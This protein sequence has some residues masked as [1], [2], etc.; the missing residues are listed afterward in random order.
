LLLLKNLLFAILVPGLIAGWIPLRYFARVVSWPAGDWRWPQPA[1]LLLFVISLLLL[2][3]CLWLF[4][5]YGHGTPAPVDP[6]V[7]LVQRGAYRWVRNP[8]YL[9]VLGVVAGE[10]LFL[11][12]IDVA[13]YLFCLGCCFQLFG[14]MYEDYRREV[15]RWWP[16]APRPRK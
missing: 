13:V 7:K 14:A 1:G 11:W 9:G 6:P 16:R 12:S 8:M 10:G 2:L 5:T 15:P 3:H 4:A